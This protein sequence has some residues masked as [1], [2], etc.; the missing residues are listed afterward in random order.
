ME[1]IGMFREGLFSEHTLQ[2][3][4]RTKLQRFDRV[5]LFPQ[6]ARHG[7]HI[8]A[9]NQAANQHL[10]LVFRQRID[11]LD[12]GSPFIA[13]L[14]TPYRVEVGMA[15][16]DQRVF[17]C[18]FLFPKP[19]FKRDKRWL[20][21]ALAIIAGDGETGDLE[22]PGGNAG[23]IGRPE[24]ADALDHLQKYIGGQVF[25]CGAIGHA[26]SNIAKYPWQELAVESAQRLRIS[27]SR[28]IKLAFES[29]HWLLTSVGGEGLPSIVAIWLIVVTGARKNN[30]HG[31]FVYSK[32]RSRNQ[33]LAKGNS[34]HG[35]CF[36][37]SY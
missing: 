23:L 9:Q 7:R 25:R 36:H 3:L 27:S 33:G 15:R 10:A 26:G 20:M 1:R 19:G 28:T 11:R 17:P 24:P 32:G 18:W 12:H 37:G 30:A 14:G 31:H 29:L 35:T 8:I 22:D 6:H 16:M 13:C 21:L 2:A 5:R 4:Q 34:H